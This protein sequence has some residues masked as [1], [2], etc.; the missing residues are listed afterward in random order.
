MQLHVG[1]DS[2]IIQ[3]GNYPDFK[4][5]ERQRFALEFYSAT[6][7][8]PSEPGKSLERLI[9]ATYKAQG[10]V[11]HID[12]DAW[13]CDFGVLAYRDE[14]PPPWARP[15]AG[16]AGDIYLGVD[17]YAYQE[18][19]RTR[20]QFPQ[21][22]YDVIVR[23]IELETTPWID[24]VSASGQRVRERDSSRTSFRHIEGTNA[25]HD[26]SQSAHYVLNCELS[27]VAT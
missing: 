22:S 26:D 3:D 11:V 18:D 7:L 15:G 4:S 17:H 9:G 5:G 20:S 10:V 19:L 24:G 1:I 23:G 16:V 13:V 8:K 14:P 6:G 25:W 21:L 2:W 12:T 27:G